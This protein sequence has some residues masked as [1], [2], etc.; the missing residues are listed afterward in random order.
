MRMTL[1]HPVLLISVLF[2]VCAC[3]TSSPGESQFAPAPM[4]E[5]AAVRSMDQDTFEVTSAR[6]VELEWFHGTTKVGVKFAFTYTVRADQD[7]LAAQCIECN[8]AAACAGIPKLC[9]T[10]SATGPLHSRFDLPDAEL[11][12]H[13]TEQLFP[14]LNGAPIATVKRIH[15]HFF[16]A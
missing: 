2:A 16:G 1:R 11:R 3:Q 9:D 13:L 5:I 4:G 8:L 10:W 14:C 12:A 7:A 15:W 6:I